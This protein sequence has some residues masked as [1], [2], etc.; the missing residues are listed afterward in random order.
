MA[1]PGCGGVDPGG[2][3][4]GPS[5]ALWVSLDVT[6]H[7]AD[8]AMPYSLTLRCDPDGGTV[9]DPATACAEL[10]ADPAL[11]EPQPVGHVIACPMILASSGLAVVDGTYLG[12]QVDETIMD[13]G[14]DLHRWA[15]L[16][17]IFRPAG[18]GLQPVSPGYPVVP[19]GA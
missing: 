9:P 3:V 2:P 7:P 6:I 18:S 15:E 14:C 19:S 13:G 16:M 11:L 1:C 10:L 8:N 4:I 5:T 12:R 17:Q